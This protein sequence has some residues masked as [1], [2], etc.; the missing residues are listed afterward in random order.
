MPSDSSLNS[1][2]NTPSPEGWQAFSWSPSTKRLVADGKTTR[3]FRPSE[4]QNL[5]SPPRHGNP[6]EFV[7]SR[8]IRGCRRFNPDAAGRGFFELIPLVKHAHR[9]LY[10]PATTRNRTKRW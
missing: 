10:E 3:Q 6:A 7:R 8:Q 4:A 2:P 5:R 9:L 1:K